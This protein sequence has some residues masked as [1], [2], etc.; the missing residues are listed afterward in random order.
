MTQ[1]GVPKFIDFH[2]GRGSRGA[3]A[4]PYMYKSNNENAIV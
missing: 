1:K 2:R 4:W 3:K